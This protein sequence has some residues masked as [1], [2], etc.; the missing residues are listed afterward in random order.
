MWLLVASSS[1]E[2]QV[3]IVD[4]QNADLIEVTDDSSGV[5]RRMT[6]NVRLRQDTTSIR[7]DRVIE[8]ERQRL[9]LLSGNVRIVS[10]R[11]TLTARTVTYDANTKVSIAEGNVRVGNGE[12][13]LYAPSTR[14]DSRA[15]VSAFEG[16]GRI[17]NEGA[18][19]IAPSGTYDSSRRFARLDGPVSLYDSTG[20][21]HAA[22][23]TYDARVQRADFAGE[24]RLWRPDARMHA[25]SVVYF[26]RTERARAYGQVVLQ[27]IGE[28]GTIE[29]VGQAPADSSARTL[30][31]GEELLFDGQEDRARVRGSETRDPLLL[32]LKADSTGRV[33]T[34]LARAPRID[35]FEE[36]T[37]GGDTLR[38]LIAAGGAQLTQRDLAARADS[39]HLVRRESRAG[40]PSADRFGFFGQTRPRVW[41]DGSQLTADT[42]LAS[43]RA[44]AVDTVFAIGAPFAAQLDSTLGRVQQLKGQRMRALF[45]QDRIRQLD[46]WPNAEAIYHLADGEGRFESV[47]EITSDSLAFGFEDGEVRNVFGATGNQGTQTAGNL[48]TGRKRLSGFAFSP[49]EAPTAPSVLDV[50]G[51]EAIWLR[52]YGPSLQDLLPLLPTTASTPRGDP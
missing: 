42:L 49:R 31:F 18:T 52:T 44:G 38:V 39:V 11:D 47:I 9:Y 27:R 2:A 30:L 33:D 32:L 8:Y 41:A 3:R 37:E 10:G 46:V 19:L 34:T 16:G 17:L 4:I 22:R 51:W 50:D 28:S 40:G 12:S 25:D 6:G 15:E 36:A 48:V 13:T 20:T 7:A 23:G 45:D 21:L 35:V 14:Y 5:V 43:A 24:V 1:V 29:R 26:R